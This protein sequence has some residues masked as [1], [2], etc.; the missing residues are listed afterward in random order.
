M[1]MTPLA[2]TIDFFRVEAEFA[3]NLI[4]V[5]SDS[6]RALR[7]HLIDAMHLNRTADR[8]IKLVAGPFQRNDDF[9]RS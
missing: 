7:R 2:Q 4:V 8:R 9:V 5:L 6:R 1:A 3:K